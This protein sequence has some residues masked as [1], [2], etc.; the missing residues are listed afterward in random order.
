MFRL[1]SSSSAPR[2]L[3]F[4]LVLLAAAPV[5]P[6]AAALSSEASAYLRAQADSAVQWLPWG[7]AAFARAKQEQ[8]P[9]FLSIGTATSELSRAMHRQ[10][11]ANAETAAFLNEDFVCILVD[12]KERPD[13]AALYQTY[14]R[15]VKQ[16]SGLPL[17]IWLTPELKPFEGAN[18]LPPTEEWGKEG[19]LTVARRAASAWK[20]DAAAQRAKA[21]EAIATV[22]AAQSV[23]APAPVDAAAATA[24]LAAARDTWIARLDAAHGGFGE[25]PKYLEPELHRFL[26]RDPASREAAVASLRHVVRSALR[27]PLD[28]GFFRYAQDPELRQ[29]YFQ[30]T[31]VDQARIALALLDAA[32]LGGGPEFASAAAGALRYALDR[33]NDPRD[34]FLAAE[35][36]TP[37]GAAPVY[38]WTLAELREVL[39]DA[40]AP[41][42]AA[43]SAT[44]EGNIPADAF[45]GLDTAGKNL[46]VRTTPP[47]DAATE[48]A[49]ASAAAQLLA[50]R[51]SRPQPP[52]DDAA[53]AGAHGLMLAVLARAGVEL[54]DARLAA[55]AKAEFIFIRDRLIAADGALRRLAGRPAAAAPDDYALVASGLL[56]FAQVAKEPAADKL[57]A[58]L[59]TQAN[60]RYF[61]LPSGRYWSSDDKADP[62]LWARV[63]VPEPAAGEPPAAEPAMLL[64]LRSSPAADAPAADLAALSGAIAA[65]VKDATDAPRGDLLFSLSAPAR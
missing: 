43:C 28:G 27:D 26:L 41:F 45:A 8:K 53:T 31:L 36:A 4:A 51:Q 32:P 10:S 58:A 1:P 64:A 42:A 20:A 18:Y 56:T 23:P 50:K 55:A 5:C 47:G 49:F 9:I 60:R 15:T 2:L 24:L 61:D 3:S 35:D 54:P 38:F 19:F 13:L 25:P 37:E 12:A 44:A 7:E 16:L 22:A 17:N 39:G 6:A 21:A 62:S 34:G 57:A 11:F 40:A 65:E 63:H 30:K 48:K 14:I 59:T 33:L 46:L 52:C 29:P